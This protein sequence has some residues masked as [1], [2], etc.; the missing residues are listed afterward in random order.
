MNALARRR[1]FMCKLCQ[2]IA[3][4]Y[5]FFGRPPPL[6][7]LDEETPLCFEVFT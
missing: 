7:S 2:K 5:D 3:K 4:L 6:Q 1:N